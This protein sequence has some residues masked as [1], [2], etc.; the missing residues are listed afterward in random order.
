MGS[1]RILRP[2][3]LLAIAVILALLV[4]L[5]VWQLRRAAQKQEMFNEFTARAQGPTIQVL[6]EPLGLEQAWSRAQVTG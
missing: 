1:R 3:P 2:L 6:T 5:G 4:A